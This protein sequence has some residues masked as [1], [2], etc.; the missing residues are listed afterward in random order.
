[1]LNKVLNAEIN[2]T[3]SN[4]TSTL[5]KPFMYELEEIKVKS[6]FTYRLFIWLILSISKR[7]DEPLRKFAAIKVRLICIAMRESFDRQSMT[8]SFE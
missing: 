3:G 8:V 1:M 7:L 2:D 6:R 4:M 5:H